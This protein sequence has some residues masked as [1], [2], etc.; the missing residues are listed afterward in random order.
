MAQD[1]NLMPVD[2]S[3]CRRE[4]PALE[5]KVDG[6][7]VIF[8]DGSG[9]TQVPKSVADTVADYLLHHNANTHGY[10]ATAAQTDQ[11]L[12]D[13]RVAV[14][15]LLG[16]KPGEIA[17]GTNMTTLNYAL[18]RALGRDLKPGD[19]VV[20]TDLDHEA[21]RG[22]WLAL[23]EKGAT[24]K[25]VRVDVDRFQLDWNDFEAKVGPKTKIVAV[26]YASNAIGTI[27]DVKRAAALA[28]SVGAT[29]VIDA[30]HGAPHIPVDVRD[31]DCDF[32]LCSAYKFFGPHIGIVYGRSD[33]FAKLVPYK[34]R[35]QDDHPP[36]RLE[37]GTLCHEGIAGTTP[38]VEFIAGVGRRAAALAGQAAPADRRAAVLVGVRAIQAY[39]DVLAKKLQDGLRAI[40]GTMVYRAPDGTPR[41]PTVSS[42]FKGR[43]ADEMAKAL[44]RE[45]I[46]VWD[47]NFYATTL[48]DDIFKLVP[49]GG[50]VRM[51]LAPYNTDAEIDRALATVEGLVMQAG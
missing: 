11:I 15:D 46:F 5:M 40:P 4:F 50:L 44:G 7:P 14:A 18:S 28:H 43:R 22:P 30:V 32:L 36:Y 21:N 41:T 17:F 23:A 9:G 45:G 26:G 19:E 39:E 34:L 2:V 13:A 49:R 31:I 25:S 51:G 12:A 24:V 48:V 29:C 35:P 10:F 20:I 1:K 37:T 33:A 42:V 6:K 47:G 3:F 8:L 38:A 16:A 27:N